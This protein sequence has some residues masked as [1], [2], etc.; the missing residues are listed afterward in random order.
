MRSA[1]ASVSLRRALVATLIAFAGCA[2]RPDEK[3]GAGTEAAGTDFVCTFVAEIKQAGITT[4]PGSDFGFSG[5]AYR[6]EEIKS[7]TGGQLV[8]GFDAHWGVITTI[9][10]APAAP[11]FFRKGDRWMFV[12]HSPVITF[13]RPAEELAGRTFKLDL[14]G[15]LG[16]DG[17][18]HFDLLELHPEATGRTGKTDIPEKTSG[19]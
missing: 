1:F 18:V 11:A 6:S 12:I 15:T 13:G 5:G 2:A 9:V 16:A 3:A 7:A 14:H 10:E 17:A 19:H 8:V 4:G